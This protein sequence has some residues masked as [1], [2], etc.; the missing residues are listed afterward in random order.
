MEI[1]AIESHSQIKS[2]LRLKFPNKLVRYLHE[3]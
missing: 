2:E 1:N 3:L